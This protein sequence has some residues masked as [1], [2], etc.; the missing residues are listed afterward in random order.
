MRRP[1]FLYGLLMWLVSLVI[2][3]FLIQ[4]GGLIMSDVPTAGKTIIQDDFVDAAQL[5]A[6]DAQIA[7]SLTSL[8]EN[9]NAAEDARF[10]YNSRKL[11]YQNQRD[12]FE[13]W[14]KTRTATESADQ[15]PEVIARVTAIEALKQEERNAERVIEELQQAAAI[16]NRR[17]G[18]LNAQRSDTLNA[19]KAPYE[20]ARV[21]EVL[22]VFLIRLALTLPLLLISGWIVLK[23]RA[24]TYWPIY[25]SFVIFSLFAFFVELVPYLP[26]YGGYV[27]TIVGIVIAVLVAHF[28]IKGMGRYLEKKQSEEKQTDTERRQKIDYETAINKI[29]NCVCPSCDRKFGDPKPI[30]GAATESKVDFCVHCG[31]CL[32]S[33][34]E[35]CGERENSFYKFC[36]ACG[37]P[38]A[39]NDVSNA[40]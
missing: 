38:A 20:K 16:E 37:V 21:T 13:N 39:G 17:L 11:D 24:S 12:S 6:I 3:A 30:K 36:G 9:A 18:D 7:Q 2:S 34:C 8:R 27:R 19:A 14:I 40:R 26:S 22:K 29:S 1:Q 33:R 4:L 5:G 25:R 28:T 15:N 32:F 10:R 35:S 23:K 31:F